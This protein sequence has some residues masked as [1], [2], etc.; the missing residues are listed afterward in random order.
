MDGVLASSGI[1]VYYSAEFLL[2]R[3][4]W[5]AE[6]YGD[7]ADV[8]AGIILQNMNPIQANPLKAYPLAVEGRTFFQ[9]VIVYA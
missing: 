1:A 4:G 2:K 8:A 9:P 5:L 3:L 6:I 7:N